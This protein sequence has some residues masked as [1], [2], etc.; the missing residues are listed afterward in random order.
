MLQKVSV[1]EKHYAWVGTS[2]F[3]KENFLSHSAERFPLGTPYCVTIFEYQKSLC[4]KVV[5]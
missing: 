3:S 5:F 4:L 1:F 2:R